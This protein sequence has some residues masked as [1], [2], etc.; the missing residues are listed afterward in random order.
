MRSTTPDSPPEDEDQHNPDE[1]DSDDDERA[2]SAEQLRQL[3]HSFD[4]RVQQL[5]ASSQSNYCE[6]YTSYR[7]LNATMDQ[8]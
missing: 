1:P 3:E 4:E 7:E 5:D 2:V 8:V 6:L